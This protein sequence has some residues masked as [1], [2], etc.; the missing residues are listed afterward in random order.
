MSIST[1]KLPVPK[2]L[3]GLRSHSLISICGSA[4]TFYKKTINFEGINF[5]D[6]SWKGPSDLSK[7]NKI[8]STIFIKIRVYDNF[9]LKTICINKIDK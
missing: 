1:S 4:L 2:P 7:V 9:N 3:R 8:P 5:H 6:Y